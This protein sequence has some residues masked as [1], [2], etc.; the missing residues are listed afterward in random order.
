MIRRYFSL[1]AAIASICGGKPATYLA[2][3]GTKAK[4]GLQQ[5]RDEMVQM[6]MLKGK[7][8]TMFTMYVYPRATKPNPAAIQ[9]L[10]GLCTKPG[11][12]T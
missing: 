7:A 8:D 4:I 3:E 5:Q 11:A 1:P 10:R 6:V 2:L 12:T 9:A